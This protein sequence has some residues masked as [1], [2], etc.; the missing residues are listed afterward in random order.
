MRVELLRRRCPGGPALHRGALQRSHLKQ[1]KLREFMS[2]DG[3]QALKQSTDG[4]ILEQEPTELG[5][6]L[7]ANDER[8]GEE[9]TRVVIDSPQTNR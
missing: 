8:L 5:R 6:Q 2:D 9:E 1:D 7:S 3:F 4:E